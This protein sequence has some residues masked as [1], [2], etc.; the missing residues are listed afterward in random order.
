MYSLSVFSI[1]SYSQYYRILRN[2]AELCRVSRRRASRRR[3]PVDV[4]LNGGQIVGLEYP[5]HVPIFEVVPDAS[6]IYVDREAMV[7]L[8]KVLRRVSLLISPTANVAADEAGPDALFD[9]AWAAQSLSG[10]GV[11]WGEGLAD[12]AETLTGTPT[13]GS[14]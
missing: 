3:F 10:G 11:G 5:V 8:Q 2:Y 12:F 6:R 14:M 13:T 9:P 7:R 1:L 4:Q